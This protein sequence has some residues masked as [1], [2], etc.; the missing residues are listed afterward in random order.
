MT[1]GFWHF[2]FNLL[3]VSYKMEERHLK[4]IAMCPIILKWK[5]ICCVMRNKPK[6]WVHIVLFLSCRGVFDCHSDVC[7]GFSTF[8]FSPIFS[9]YTTNIGF[10]TACCWLGTLLSYAL[11]LAVLSAIS[12][13]R[14]VGEHCHL[15]FNLLFDFVYDL[16]YCQCSVIAWHLHFLGLFYLFHC[17]GQIKLCSSSIYLTQICWW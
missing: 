8:S 11:L 9:C 13:F 7:R 5:I 3:K 4:V 17:T 15:A 1:L 14:Q 16:L 12:A 10:G 2:Q 6:E